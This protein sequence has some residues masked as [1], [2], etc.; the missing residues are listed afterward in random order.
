MTDGADRLL[1]SSSESRP[2]FPATNTAA[3]EGDLPAFDKPP[4]IEVAASLQF[5]PIEDLHAVRLGLLWEAYRDRYPRVEVHPPLE[6]VREVIG[7]PVPAKLSFSVGATMPPPRYW[8][9][10]ERGTQMIQVQQTRFVLN[11]RKMDTEV[12]YPHYSNIR[13]TLV[14]EFGRFEQ[15]LEDE[16]L[17]GPQLNQ[18]ELTYV[19]HIPVAAGR[20][21]ETLQRIVRL[22]RG[23]PEASILPSAEDIQFRA[24]YVMPNM[25]SPMGRLYVTSETRLRASNG[26][27]VL[28]L[29][30]LARGAPQGAGFAG[31][32]AFMDHGHRWIVQ[33]FADI[34]T[35]E[36]HGIWERSQ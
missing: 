28:S 23:E 25:D 33:S 15:F 5:D 24:R 27:P 30:L 12:A 4:V 21:Q 35:P 26:V 3:L 18:A 36:M 13:D 11:W 20:Q 9:L 29:T 17:A 10:N 31:G 34:T 7:P 16:S 6:S 14:E 2:P 22:W 32:L 1:P 19:N 8:F